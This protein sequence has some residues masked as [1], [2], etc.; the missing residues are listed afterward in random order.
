MAII[1]KYSRL[2]I[3]IIFTANF[4]WDKITYKLLLS[5]TAIDKPNLVMYIFCIKVAHLL[6]N[7]KWK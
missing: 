5:Q 1:Y 7:L 3:F 6:Y 4:K 2:S